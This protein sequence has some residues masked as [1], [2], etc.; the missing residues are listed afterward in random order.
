MEKLKVL[1]AAS[2]AT[3][4]IKTGGL[5]DV[6]GS[7][8]RALLDCG[9]DVRVVLP[10]YGSIPWE[11]VSRMRHVGSLTVDVAWRRQFCAVLELELDGVTHYFIDNEGY[12]KRPNIYGYGDEAE[13]Y[14]FFSKA[15]LE[16]LPAIGFR[17]DV[18]HANDWQTAFAPIAMDAW[19]RRAGYLGSAATLLTI[20]NMRYQGVMPAE[21]MEDMLALDWSYFRYDRMEWHGAVN[22]LKSGINFADAVTTVSETYASEIMHEP[23][24]EGLSDVL[25]KRA[26]DLHGILNGVDYA[27]MSPE[28]DRYIYANYGPGSVGLKRENKVRLQAELDLNVDPHVPM[29]GI[30]SRLVDQKGFDLIERVIGELLGADMQ[31]VVLGTGDPR[32]EDMFRYAAYCHPD[33]VS[34]SIR[35]DNELSHKIYAGCDM[36]LMPSFFEPCGLSQLY[37]LRYGTVPIVR[38]TGGLNDT[39][40][41]YEEADGSG[42]GFT[43]ANYNA[44]D[45]L[46][47]VRRALGV[48]ADKRAWGAI[49]ARG[50]AQ[51]FS[52][53]RSARRYMDVYGLIAGR[54]R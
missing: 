38:E 22:L 40:R 16:M 52:W 42:N 46:H 10:K 34:A 39:V 37:A 18:I 29:V 44:H 11:Y 50:M 53:A 23:F 13:R 17:P 8:P 43:F 28:K 14:V 15:M 41:A 33:K 21:N 4:F 9:A 30:V 36:L 2:E 5:A 3:P 51:D 54:R 35:F 45:M 12:F 1:Y 24:G 48:Y 6:A 20:H 27:S 7:L 31:I 26:G 19:Y 32:Y 49:M 47:T 25:R